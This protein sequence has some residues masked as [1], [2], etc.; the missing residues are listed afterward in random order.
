M[1]KINSSHSISYEWAHNFQ[2]FI[3]EV[4]EIVLIKRMLTNNRSWPQPCHE[5]IIGRIW[6]ML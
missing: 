1:E 3:R 5:A 2:A 6:T 4:Q